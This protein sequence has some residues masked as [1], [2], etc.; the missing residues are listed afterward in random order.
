MKFKTSTGT[1][2][3]DNW[4]YQLQGSNGGPQDADLLASATHDLLV[5]DSSRDGSNAGRFLID[6]VSRMKDG[7]GGRS[8]LVSYIS[9]GEASDFRDYWRK[10]WTIHGEARDVLTA[11]APDWL[12]P[13]NPDWPESRKVRFWDEEWQNTMFNDRKTGDVDTIV[14]SGFD[15]AYLDIVDAYYFWGA[16]VAPADR[17]PGD[18]VNEKQ[19]A[20]R[21]VDFVV[22]LTARARE[23]N[24][25][26]F[27]VPQNGAWILN[28]LG[29]DAG[30][31]KA[32]MDAIGGIAI[33]DLYYRGDK[34]ENNRLDPDRDMI[35]M[36][37][38]D[39]ISKGIPV[40][41]V[42]YIDGRDRVDAFNKMALKDGFIPFAAPERDLDRLVGTFD[43]DP[44]YIRP[45]AKDDTLHGSKVADIING[46]AGD[47]R[48]VGRGGNDKLVG[49]VGDDELWGGTGTDV[50]TG[51]AGR[52]RF[53]FDTKLSGKNVDTIGDFHHG[54]DKLVLDH[55]VFADMPIG[56]LKA[57]AFH[58]GP[59]A[60]D[61][62]DRIIYDST[63]GR[64]FYDADGIGGD[65]SVQFTKL[66]PHL[67]V[68][69]NDF[70]IF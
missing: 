49:G 38:R 15:A 27:V 29:N 54:R 65:P 60:H 70:L 69:A 35:A 61:R 36:L 39:Y 12:G 41:V 42:D 68:G 24:P 31:K 44:A 17:R 1:V 2:S 21:M 7:M 16:E 30:R 18:P 37:K 26:F 10:E 32:Y 48:I 67:E 63:S 8:V 20:Q 56:A 45:T 14:K 51:G 62:S 53:V 40:F 19:A 47:D 57:G 64:L 11:K 33:E 3:V 66:S 6:E 9:I 5:I 55:A 46:L 43:G 52:D 13:V 23:T 25:D 59:E 58:I 28:D 50:M 34:D 4:G 22:D